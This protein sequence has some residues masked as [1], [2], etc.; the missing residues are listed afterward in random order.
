MIFSELANIRRDRVGITSQQ[1]DG[2]PITDSLGNAELLT[3][4]LNLYFTNEPAGDL[5][6]KGFSS[7]PTMPDITITLQTYST[8]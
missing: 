1:S 8:V 5:P 7:H 6:N 2:N 4:N 3:N